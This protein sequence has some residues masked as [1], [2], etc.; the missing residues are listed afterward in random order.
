MLVIAIKGRI[1][2]GSAIESIVN[3]NTESKLGITGG[4]GYKPWKYHILFGGEPWKQGYKTCMTTLS[5][6]NRQVQKWI[7]LQFLKKEFNPMN[8]E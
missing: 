3:S 7:V 5:S 1:W 6:S 8:C 4:A 2:V